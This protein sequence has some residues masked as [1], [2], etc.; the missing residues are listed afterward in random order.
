MNDLQ[1]IP[2]K[3]AGPVLVTL[4]PPFE[5]RGEPI[6]GRWPYEHPVLDSKVGCLVNTRPSSEVIVSLYP[7]GRFG[8]ERDIHHTEQTPYL[9]RWCLPALWL[10]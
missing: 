1:H 7:V 4:N 10:P 9:L 3:S 2:E 8:T 6:Q 5:S